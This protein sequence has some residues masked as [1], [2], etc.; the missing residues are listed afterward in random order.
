MYSIQPKYDQKFHLCARMLAVTRSHAGQ[1]EN[2][3]KRNV[4]NKTQASRFYRLWQ[5]IN[6]SSLLKVNKV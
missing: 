1:K 5:I 6:D 2:I 3:C 4:L